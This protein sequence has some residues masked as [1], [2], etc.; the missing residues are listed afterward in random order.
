[1]ADPNPAQDAL[2]DTI[3]NTTNA[4]RDAVAAAR[5]AAFVDKDMMTAGALAATAAQSASAVK[6]MTEALSQLRDVFPEL[7]TPPA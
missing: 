7:K 2:L 1:M 6:D 5:N 3:W 4:V